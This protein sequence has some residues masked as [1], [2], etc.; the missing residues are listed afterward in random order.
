MKNLAC[1]V[2]LTASACWTSMT[3]RAAEPPVDRLQALQRQLVEQS[4]KLEQLRALLSEQEDV[5]ASLREA[6]GEEILESQRGGSANSG[7]GAS[8]LA[9]AA[10]ETTQAAPPEPVGEAPRR[11]TRAPEVARIF[12]EPT[13]LTR[14]GDFVLEPSLQSS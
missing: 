4:A 14:G 11:E 5:I 8:T 13:A 6:V 12:S 3:V 10:A 2:V 9:L 1:A 7:V